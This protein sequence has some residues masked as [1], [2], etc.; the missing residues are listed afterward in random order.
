MSNPRW[1]RANQ[2]LAFKF[3]G[4]F[5]IIAKIGAAAYRLD[6]PESSAVHP[7]FHVSQ[8]KE[9]V[10]PQH[11]VTPNIPSALQSFQVPGC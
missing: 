2:K 1:H 3:F 9:F 4:P 11:Q 7:M 8:L 5:K 10:G 6:L